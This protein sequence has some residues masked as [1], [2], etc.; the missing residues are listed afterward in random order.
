MQQHDVR[1][2]VTMAV[3]AVRIKRV[4]MVRMLE[5]LTMLAMKKTRP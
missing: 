4:V 3:T 5:N 2:T 1:A